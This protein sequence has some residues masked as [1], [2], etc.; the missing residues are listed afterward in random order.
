MTST[1]LSLSSNGCS[2]S[3]PMRFC[4]SAA[5]AGTSCAHTTHRPTTHPGYHWADRVHALPTSGS[6]APG[7]RSVLPMTGEHP[8]TQ[9]HGTGRHR[10]AD[11]VYAMLVGERPATLFDDRMWSGSVGCGAHGAGDETP[12]HTQPS[13]S[14]W[15]SLL[16]PVAVT[17]PSARRPSVWVEPAATATMSRQ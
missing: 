16:F 5:T 12:A 10:L 8:T 4:R 1:A 9:D 7:A 3:R 13:M 15:P 6:A 2:S 11:W 14:H 17:V